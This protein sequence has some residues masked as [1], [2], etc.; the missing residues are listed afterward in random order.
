MKNRILLSAVVLLFCGMAF[1]QQ[2]AGKL[3][4]EVASVK[5]SAPQPMGM[6]RVMRSTDKGMVRYMGNSLQD[7]I[8]TAYRVKDFQIE[9]PDWLNSERFD[10]VAK[11]PEGVSEDQVPEML[12]SLLE[13]RFKLTL[14]RDTKEHAIYALVVGKNGAK[15]KESD[16]QTRDTVPPQ[17]TPGG[18]APGTVDV[19][20]P[21]PAGNPP[22]A[23]SSSASTSRQLGPGE[24]GL[25]ALNPNGPPPKGGVMFMMEQ[26]GMHMKASAMTMPNLADMLSRFTERPIVDMTSIKGRYDFDLAFAP[27]TMRGLPRAPGPPPPGAGGDRPIGP[28]AAEPGASVFDAVQQYGLKLEPRKAPMEVLTIDH[29]EKT[30]TEN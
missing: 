6:F 3:E 7:I 18:G 1:G 19:D 25:P 11:I 20:R 4:F 23:G 8:R 12:Q 13:E 2:P 21:A 30:P 17:G 28:D 29:I 5:P 9:G 24:K 14:H 22:A 26:G 27:E 10:I 16:V 15:L